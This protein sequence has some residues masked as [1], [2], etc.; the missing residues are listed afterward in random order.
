MTENDSIATEI[1]NIKTIIENYSIILNGINTEIQ[2]GIVSG[3]AHK[4]KII[5]LVDLGK[6][7]F[8][9]TNLLQAKIETL[10]VTGAKYVPQLK[11]IR[12]LIKAHLE[13]KD[14]TNER[15][16]VFGTNEEN[17]K[18]KYRD[19][20]VEIVDRG[21]KV[22]KHNTLL[23]DEEIASLIIVDIK[24]GSSFNGMKDYHVVC[25]FKSGYGLILEAMQKATREILKRELGTRSK[26]DIRSI[27]NRIKNL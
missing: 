3:D 1:Q 16:R 25:Y 9:E 4:Q 22:I 19:L 14:G 21:I 5:V 10:K 23:K 6:R 11:A 20:R 26:S 13:L 15:W 8:N 2:N 24:E 12:E 27:E 7:I 17:L 18:K